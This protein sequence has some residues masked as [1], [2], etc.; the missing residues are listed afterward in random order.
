MKNDHPLLTR[1]KR[2]PLKPVDLTPDGCVYDHNVGAWRHAVSG[3][4]WIDTSDRKGAGT[5]KNDIETGEDQ[6]GE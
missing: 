1:A 2:Y 5:K 6:K 3:E 4:L